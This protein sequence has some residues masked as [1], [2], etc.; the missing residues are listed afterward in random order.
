MGNALKKREIK[1]AFVKKNQELFQCPICRSSLEVAEFQRFVCSNGHSFDFAK[2][3]YVNLLTKP[4]KTKYDKTLF[5][6]RKIIIN[7]SPLYKDLHQVIAEKLNQM[8]HGKFTIADLGCGEGSHLQKIGKRFDEN[9]TAVGLDISKEGILLAA[10]SY[11]KPIWL[12]GDLAQLPFQDRSIHVILNILSPSNYQEFT[13]VLSADGAILKVVPG[14]NYLQELRKIFFAEEKKD[15]TQNTRALF[16]KH[17]ELI[18]VI[19]IHRTYSISEEH[20]ESLLQMTPLLWSV[21]SEQL[22]KAGKQLKEIT[23]DLDILVGRHNTL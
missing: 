13:R 7:D 23:V 15:S 21:D 8:V 14:G 17:F 22:E 5:Q 2:Q 16:Q 4:P 19:N 12:V 1:A 18:E 9:V 3:G 11:E 10:K 6:A 20:V